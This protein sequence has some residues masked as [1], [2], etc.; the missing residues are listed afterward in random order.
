ML[1][2]V[3]VIVGV[4][5]CGLL[6]CC[7]MIELLIRCCCALMCLRCLG[8]LLFWLRVLVFVPAFRLVWVWHDVLICSL[9]G[10]CVRGF[11]PSGFVGFVC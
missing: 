11:V 3:R 7:G 9:F 5:R 8:W 2:L 6:V 1:F 10:S 4:C